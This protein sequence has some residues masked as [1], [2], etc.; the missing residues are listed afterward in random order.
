MHTLHQV[1]ITI[2]P[3]LTGQAVGPGTQLNLST[4][5]IGPLPS[6]AFWEI[7]VFTNPGELLVARGFTRRN[8]TPVQV[9]IGLDQ[10]ALGTPLSDLLPQ[11][12]QSA[13]PTTG[14]LTVVLKQDQSTILEQT[15][16]PIVWRPDP[17][18]VAYVQQ[19]TTSSTTTGGFTDTD[20]LVLNSTQ[21]SVVSSLPLTV[22]IGGTLDIGLDQ[23][24]KGP[25][26]DFLSEGENLLLTGRGTIT[27][28]VGSTGVYAYGGRWSIETAPAGLGRLDGQAILYEQR[29]AQFVVVKNRLGGGQYAFAI[30]D[31]HY[32]S[33]EISWPIPFPVRID[34]DILPGVTV[35]WRW[36]LL[37]Q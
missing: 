3:P 25:P 23:L 31:S 30:E 32:D 2:T 29:I 17:A 11:P 26:I 24:Q 27:R 34:F 21:A 37:L 14:L 8:E 22:P 35:R 6:T 5:F 13:T 19:A 9:W 12:P 36:L 1:P 7:N 16:G 20:R 18:G 28:T 33:G 10:P 15:S 4:D